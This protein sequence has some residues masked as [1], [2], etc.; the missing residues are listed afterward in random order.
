MLK[1]RKVP[2]A[3]IRE[4]V[5][6]VLDKNTPFAISES[7]R[8]LQTNSLYLPIADK[9]KKI[10]ITSPVS[11]EGKSYISVNLSRTLA[12]NTGKKVVLIDMDM[13]VPRVKKLLNKKLMETSNFSGLSE[14]LA[15]I[16][17]KP[18]II[19]TDLENFDVILSGKET[20][21]PIGLINSPKMNALLDKLAEKYDY[22]IIDTP[23]VNIVT[24]A[25]L[26]LDK[27]NG[28]VL[29]SRANYSNINNLNSAI[30]AIKNVG[31]EVFG[32]VLTDA[33]LKSYA[34]SKYKYP[35]GDYH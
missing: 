1:K 6:R 18:N 5:E 26:M 15:D 16:D 21:N 13:R 8:A 35:R 34:K 29:S 19:K 11:G 25:L 7:F 24:D 30:D 9:C 14:Y 10:A 27:V 17:S 2:H 28:Y 3:L 4:D 31:G 33:N 20:S 23:P 32:V 22:I 12:I